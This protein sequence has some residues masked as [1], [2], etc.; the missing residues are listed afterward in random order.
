ME[1][2]GVDVA[3]GGEELCDLLEAVVLGSLGAFRVMVQ[4]L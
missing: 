2:R 3:P 1:L 4:G